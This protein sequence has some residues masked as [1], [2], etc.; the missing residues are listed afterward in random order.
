MRLTKRWCHLFLSGC[1]FAESLLSGIT[2]LFPI[3]PRLRKC[4][5][6]K[7]AHALKFGLPLITLKAPHHQPNP[8][9]CKKRAKRT[10]MH[11]S[12]E[13]RTPDLLRFAFGIM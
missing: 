9:H 6:K 1:V 11:T 5:K 7:H 3:E 10:L 8:L 13:D 4:E 2:G 12:G